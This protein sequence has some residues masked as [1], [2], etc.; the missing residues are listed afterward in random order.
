MTQPTRQFADLR[1]PEKPVGEPKAEWT[2]EDDE[3][4]QAYTD[5]VHKTMYGALGKGNTVEASPVIVESAVRDETNEE[6]RGDPNRLDDYQ[7]LIDGA[8]GG[9]GDDPRARQFSRDVAEVKTETEEVVMQYGIDTPYIAE[10]DAGG[11]LAAASI[12][13]GR[14]Q[15][16]PDV[17]EQIQYAAHSLELEASKKAM[18]ATAI[19]D[20]LYG[21]DSHHMHDVLSSFTS[22]DAADVARR[23]GEIVR[24]YGDAAHTPNEEL[25]ILGAY[26]ESLNSADETMSDD[27]K[28]VQ[29]FGKALDEIETPEDL[30]AAVGEEKQEQ[31]DPVEDIPYVDIYLEATKR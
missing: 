8:T 18:L 12:D 25:A 20:G 28:T 31:P 14:R 19:V 13:S 4:F 27:E 23:A 21:H 6:L 26:I 15:Q 11:R 5:A 2:K 16:H 3:A 22:D 17:S 30:L 24:K 1:T 10:G 7:A 9:G 29:E